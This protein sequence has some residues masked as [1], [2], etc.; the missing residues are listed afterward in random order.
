MA[1]SASR[2][3]ELEE[4]LAATERRLAEAE[5]RG[6]SALLVVEA[7]A[8]EA[9]A[10]L[11]LE[12]RRRAAA[13]RGAAEAE[14]RHGAALAKMRSKIEKAE[15]EA[16]AA[17]A[18]VVRL[19]GAREEEGRWRRELEAQ[20]DRRT[21]SESAAREA[22]VRRAVEAAAR[23]ARAEALA[24]A[25]VAEGARLEDRRK[26]EAAAQERAVIDA[27]AAARAEAESDAAKH[28][29]AARAEM[30]EEAKAV[31]AAEVAALSD[32]RVAEV[33]A[34][35]EAALATHARQAAEELKT[36]LAA[37]RAEAAESRAEAWVEAR[38]VCRA[39]LEAELR[40]AAKKAD[41]GGSTDGLPGWARAALA[42]APKQ[43]AA[44]DADPADAAT[45]GG[46]GA[47]VDSLER[48]RLAWRREAEEGARALALIQA[49]IAKA[50]R[51]RGELRAGVDAVRRGEGPAAAAAEEAAPAGLD[52]VGAAGGLLADDFQDL[53]RRCGAARAG[54]A[55]SPAAAAKGGG[56]KEMPE[57]VEAMRRELMRVSD[58]L[59]AQGALLEQREAALKE[60]TVTNAG[61][62]KRVSISES[63]AEAMSIT[64]EGTTAAVASPA[65]GAF[66]QSAVSPGGGPTSP[67]RAQCAACA[68]YCAATGTASPAAAQKPA[69]DAAPPP[70]TPGSLA[71]PAP[72]P[73]PV[74]PPPPGKPAFAREVLMEAAWAPE[75][76]VEAA[77][78]APQTPD[79]EIFRSSVPG[80]KAS[81]ATRMS[82]P[83]SA[84][85]GWSSAAESPRGDEE[86]E[87][88]AVEWVAAVTGVPRP[89]GEPL[90][91]WLRN[92]IVLC[93]LANTISPGAVAKVSTSPMPF[94]Q[95]ENIE[96]YVRACAALGV[97]SQ[98][99]FV[100]VDLFEGKNL[101]AV[102]R[103][104]HSLGRVAQQ[105][106]F[107]GPSL[108]AK[109]STRN[110]RQFSEEQ[111]ALAKAMP[112]RW[113]NRGNSL[114]AAAP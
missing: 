52:H 53:R 30:R 106:G 107:S 76:V 41:A 26:D 89:A 109:L 4:K 22:E 79:S 5:V 20:S 67:R 34:R 11:E 74:A 70:F 99:L 108:G 97:P 3:L 24:E 19:E 12:R 8:A 114:E 94:K 75:V 60:A 13:E 111:M 17:A 87:Q 59:S 36:A 37:A 105:R 51:M 16:T 113:T 104:L 47:A 21:A 83:R 32:A 80:L 1:T 45:G 33:E 43:P 54:A 29:V 28:S 49:S 7:R 110:A 88:K 91:S 77:G 63:R 48:Q 98:D 38:A 56:K 6:R 65:A 44:A 78:T 81:S 68:A 31:A 84:S 39:E 2:E 10:A 64:I 57:Q 101:P 96:A 72:P 66:A 86:Q 27:R 23:A 93:A 71:P 95:M 103:N 14:A 62:R 46:G 18:R 61:L 85:S 90:Q 25:R 58:M 69:R 15:G 92:G 112:A 9:E 102:V 100:T 42:S 40:M 50:E 35:H 73:P 82:T 55:E